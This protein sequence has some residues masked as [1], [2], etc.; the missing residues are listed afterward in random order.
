MNNLE[1]LTEATMSALKGE[2]KGKLK[3]SKSFFYNNGE[4]SEK[5]QLKQYGYGYNDT[6]A[7]GTPENVAQNIEDLI[8]PGQDSVCEEIRQMINLCCKEAKYILYTDDQGFYNYI[9]EIDENGNE[10]KLLVK[11]IIRW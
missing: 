4:D 11:W 9:Y 7:F 8:A 3:E 6:S 1:K 5:N 2:L 10:V